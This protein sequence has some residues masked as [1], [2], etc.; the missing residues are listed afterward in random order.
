[1]FDESENLNSNNSNS[2]C[3]SSDENFKGFCQL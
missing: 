1:M 2:D 3:D